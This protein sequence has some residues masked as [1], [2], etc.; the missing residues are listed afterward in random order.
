[1]YILADKFAGNINNTKYSY[2]DGDTFHYSND[3]KNYR[4]MDIQK[5]HLFEGVLKRFYTYFTVHE[6]VDTNIL[7]K[8]KDYIVEEIV[9]N[10]KI[11]KAYL[12]VNI[13]KQNELINLSLVDKKSIKD[14]IIE[15]NE[16]VM[17]STEGGVTIFQ[18][19]DMKCTMF[20]EEPKEN[21]GLTY[22]C[23]ICA[24]TMTYHHK[25]KQHSFK[26]IKLFMYCSN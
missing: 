14:T 3:G 8:I 26:P 18:D 21:C 13:N 2:L 23:S 11:K 17:P 10:E 4:S 15:P 12:Q 20:Q 22:M 19:N 7:E 6:W 24:P 1:M 16:Y 5:E 9:D 25:I